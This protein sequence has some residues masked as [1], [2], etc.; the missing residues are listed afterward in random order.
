MDDMTGVFKTSAFGG[1]NKE[2]VLNFITAQKRTEADLRSAVESLDK[3]LRTLSDRLEKVSAERDEA[4]KAAADG[5][6]A[7]EIQSALSIKEAEY[8]ALEKRC[9][10]AEKLNRELE[11]DIASLR[12]QLAAEKNQNAPAPQ[13]PKSLES[14]VGTALVDARR[15]ADQMVEEAR[16]S[17]A[18]IREKTLDFITRAVKKTDII[19]AELQLCSEKCGRVFDEMRGDISSLR[20]D[21]DTAGADMSLKE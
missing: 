5:A 6:S 2:D 20:Q 19:A 13:P 1:F 10:R 14:E 4:R 16:Q 9:E 15:F 11:S 21:L 8:A 18:Q 17:A 12:V 7:R 3:Q